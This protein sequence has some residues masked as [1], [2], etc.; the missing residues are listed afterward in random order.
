ML[1]A[2]LPAPCG[3]CH[4]IIS[5]AE[6]WVAAHVVDGQPEYGYVVAHPACNERAKATPRG[7]GGA[8]R[9]RARPLGPAGVKRETGQ[10]VSALEALVG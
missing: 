5:P 6:R 10:T 2:S 4:R 8:A 1:G 7:D 3:Y 9:M